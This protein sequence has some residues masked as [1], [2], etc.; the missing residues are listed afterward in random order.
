MASTYLG[1]VVDVKDPLGLGRLRVRVSELH[2]EGSSPQWAWPSNGVM[3]G[4]GRGFFF[5]PRVGDTIRVDF[6]QGNTSRPIW[7]SGNWTAPGGPASLPA[8][9]AGQ[10]NQ[11]PLRQGIATDRWVV[12]MDDSSPGEFKIID[13]TE[14]A[15]I[16][17]KHDGSVEL[18]DGDGRSVLLD[19]AGGKLVI[20]DDADQAITLNGT[21]IDLDPLTGTG[22]INLIA[23]AT[24]FLVKGTAFLILHNANAAL[25]SAHTHAGAVAIPVTPMTLMVAGTHTSLRVKTG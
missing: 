20:K 14:G 23:A 21:S 12:V 25:Y 22:I 19:T 10:A 1:T 6:Q 24:D 11:E 18:V 4:S 13:R 3:A 5:V 9:F 8:E 17:M 2:D 16:R 7:L 15:E